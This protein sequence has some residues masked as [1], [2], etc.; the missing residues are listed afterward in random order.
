MVVT[1]TEV[2]M[3]RVQ[4]ADSLVITCQTIP[5]KGHDIVVFMLMLYANVQNYVYCGFVTDDPSMEI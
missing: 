2:D 3:A 1:I 5:L 4:A